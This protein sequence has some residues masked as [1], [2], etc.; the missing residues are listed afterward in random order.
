MTIHTA[1]SLVVRGH[2]NPYYNYYILKSL[3][4]DDHNT[5]LMKACRPGHADTVKVL[6]EHGAIVNQQNEVRILLSSQW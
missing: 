3:Q 5:A 6:L 2:I 4:S 1:G